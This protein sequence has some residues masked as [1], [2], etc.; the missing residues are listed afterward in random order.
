MTIA[1]DG[2]KRT[3]SANNFHASLADVDRLANRFLSRSMLVS[4]DFFWKSSSICSD[5][6]LM[7]AHTGSSSASSSS[8][9]SVRLQK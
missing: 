9:S 7:S 8:E 3:T 1:K 5:R 4:S 2:R 6:L